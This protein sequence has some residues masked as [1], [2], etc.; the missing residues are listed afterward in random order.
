MAGQTGLGLDQ[1]RLAA[2]HR[3]FLPCHRRNPLHHGQSRGLDD[4]V[5]I[6]QHREVRGEGGDEF[7]RPQQECGVA[8]RP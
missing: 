5:F 6:G 8:G 1:H 2:Q 4:A 7:V 3:K